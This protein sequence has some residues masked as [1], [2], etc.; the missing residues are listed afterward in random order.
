MCIF[1]YED[2][3]VF[4]RRESITFL[5]FSKSLSIT[6]LRNLL[7]QMLRFIYSFGTHASDVQNKELYKFRIKQCEQRKSSQGINLVEQADMLKIDIN[8][9]LRTPSQINEQ[10]LVK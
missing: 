2:M 4:L 7:V 1:K 3:G 5:R 6:T 9:V 8:E 10:F